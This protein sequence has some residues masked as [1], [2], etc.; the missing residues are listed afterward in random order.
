MKHTFI[1]KKTESKS[2]RLF[3]EEIDCLG[4][5]FLRLRTKNN[6]EIKTFSG[7]TA[8]KRMNSYI[9]KNNILVKVL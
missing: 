4:I 1:L 7:K 5:V 9:K 8:L 6:T 3:L 2:K